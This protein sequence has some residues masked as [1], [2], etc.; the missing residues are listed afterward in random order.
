V[1]SGTADLIS[2]SGFFLAAPDESE[3]KVSDI[4]QKELV[5]TAL[6]PDR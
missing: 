5:E 2:G 1:K 6:Y 4:G 3:Q